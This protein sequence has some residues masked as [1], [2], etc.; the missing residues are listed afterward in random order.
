M[1]F[2]FSFQVAYFQCLLTYQGTN[3]VYVGMDTG[4]YMHAK[5][6]EDVEE[7]LNSTQAGSTALVPLTER[8]DSPDHGV[9]R[10]KAAHENVITLAQ[11]TR[12]MELVHD[13]LQK[14]SQI[15]SVQPRTPKQAEMDRDIWK[16]TTDPSRT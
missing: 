4:S 7:E 15:N 6:Y 14:E 12:D 8:S 13:Q 1:P 16:S 11:F 9:I 2:Y 5:V 10:E 3:C